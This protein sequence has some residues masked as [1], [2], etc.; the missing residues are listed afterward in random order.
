MTEPI[1]RRIQVGKEIDFEMA[2]IIIAGAMEAGREFPR[3]KFWGPD[4]AQPK[5]GWIEITLR[6][7]AD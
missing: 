7:K 3:D 5:D 1:K 6:P 2:C 4:I